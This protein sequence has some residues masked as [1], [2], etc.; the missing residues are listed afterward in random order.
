VRTVHVRSQTTFTGPTHGTSADDL[1]LRVA[2]LLPV[3]LVTT[4]R[5]ANP[6][7]VGDVHYVEQASLRL[8]SLEPRR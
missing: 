8:L 4:S 2:D 5:T 1:W 7:L 6:S 3:R